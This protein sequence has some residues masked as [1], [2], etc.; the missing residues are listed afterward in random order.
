MEKLHIYIGIIR[1]KYDS[2][3]FK[4]VSIQIKNGIEREEFYEINEKTFNR[5][6]IVCISQLLNNISKSSNIVIHTP[7]NIGFSYINKL[8]KG[9]SAGKWINKDIG[10]RLSESITK[11][12]HKVTFENYGELEQDEFIKSIKGRLSANFNTKENNSRSNLI[13]NVKDNIYNDNEVANEN[14]SIFIRGACDSLSEDKNGS[15]YAILSCKGKEKPTSGNYNNTTSSRMILQGAIES[16]KML[17]RPCK[18]KFFSHTS[19]G[20]DRFNKSQKCV[21]SDLLRELF[22]LII[23]G[24]HSFEY[25]TS[26]DRQEELKEKINLIKTNNM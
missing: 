24:N 21:N 22:D 12:K 26:M 17:K 6:V 10:I 19:V 13:L 8:N 23:E 20:I 3:V 5:A 18:I 16:V 14:V 25:I 11:N 9:K 1:T 4:L 2:D 7:T 15:Y